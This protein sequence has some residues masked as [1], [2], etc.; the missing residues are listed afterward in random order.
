MRTFENRA[1]KELIPINVV[2]T[3][4]EGYSSLRSSSTV[5]QNQEF[6]DNAI[7]SKL[8]NS[9]DKSVMLYVEC[10]DAVITPN[11]A[12]AQAHASA[13]AFCSTSVLT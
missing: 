3:E 9:C 5:L 2:F 10:E 12:V 8:T 11:F 6:E 13:L 4:V 1:R 7:K